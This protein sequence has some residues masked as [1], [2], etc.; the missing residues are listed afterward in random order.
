MELASYFDVFPEK[1]RTELRTARFTRDGATS[2]DLVGGTFIFTEYFCTKLACHCDRVLVKVFRAASEDARPEEVASISYS[3]NPD[4]DATWSKLNAEMPNPYLD[5]LHLQA[6]YA[7][8]LL[9]FWVAMVKRDQ[10]Y[11]LR[12]QHHYNEI[13][14]EIGNRAETW[15]QPNSPH[16]AGSATLEFDPADGRSLLPS[17]ADGATT[18]PPRT[19]RMRKSRKKLLARARRRR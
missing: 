19:K 2:D 5:P 17:G 6:P 3:W 7:E 13:R 10:A 14:S 16:D 8:E 4:S 11:A 15:G 9:D 18:G 1:T 12:L